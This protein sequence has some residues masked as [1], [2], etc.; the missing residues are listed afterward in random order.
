MTAPEIKG[1]KTALYGYVVHVVK[2][3]NLTVDEKGLYAEPTVYVIVEHPKDEKG[4]YV[5]KVKGDYEKEYDWLDGRSVAEMY[6]EVKDAVDA[7]YT[8]VRE[9]IAAFEALKELLEREGITVSATC[10]GYCRSKEDVIKE[11][12]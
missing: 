7:L 1:E 11:L 2:K 6:R 5:Y 12:Q 10:W 9:K 8:M 4:C 3:V